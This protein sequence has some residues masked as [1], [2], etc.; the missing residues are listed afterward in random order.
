MEI[1]V[2]TRQ[3]EGKHT[4]KHRQLER[5]GC[6]LILGQALDH[7]DYMLPAGRVSVDTKRNLAE[8]WGNLKGSRKT[9]YGKRVSNYPRFRRECI[10]ANDADHVLVVLVENRQ[11]ISD[12]AGLSCYIEPDS[13]RKKRH[14][15]KR[16]NG[17]ELAKQ[18]NT[19][20][21][22]YGVLWAFCHPAQTGDKIIEYLSREDELLA[23]KKKVMVSNEQ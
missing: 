17:K 21:K 2:D 8:I 22:E 12:L 10:R 14:A 7:G 23:H 13:G 11:G 20:S 15:K 9:K 3:H 4:Y 6:T 19:I 1:I 18:M 16:I 5:R